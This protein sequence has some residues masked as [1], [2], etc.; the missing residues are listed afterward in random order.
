MDSVYLELYEEINFD[1]EIE[2]YTGCDLFFVMSHDYNNIGEE[3]Y[4]IINDGNYLYN[5]MRCSIKGSKWKPET[6]IF[7]MNYLHELR[8]LQIELRTPTVSSGNVAIY[9]T[10][11]I[12]NF[13]IA[14]RG[15]PRYISGN[16]IRDRIVR[17]SFVD[18]ILY[19]QL[20]KYLIYENCAS[21]QGKG[22]TKQRDILDKQLRSYY[23]T[24]NHSYKGYILLGDFS[25]FF[26][27][28]RHDI[29]LEDVKSK[30]KDDY[31]MMLL[32]TILKSFEIDVS[33]LT[34]EEY[35]SCLEEKFDSLAY[36]SIPDE[37]KTG[38][39]FMQKSV[40][41][42]DHTAQ[43]I[44]VYY[45]TPIDNYVKIVNSIKYYGRYMDDF[46]IISESKEKL[47]VLLDGIKEIANKL[48]L[49]LNEKK[50]RIVKLESGFTFLQTKYVPKESGYVIKKI[51]KKRI[52]CMKRKLRKLAKKMDDGEVSYDLIYDMYNS[53]ICNYKNLMTIKQRESL[54]SLYNSLFIY[55][56]I[57]KDIMKGVND[58]E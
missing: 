19:P 57:G 34:D 32:K 40:N 48:G 38:E 8:K 28:I 52:I 27:N 54:D 17:H 26:D 5:S 43:V 53:W 9:E 45:P 51:N 56:F 55:P 6:Q 49:F 16:I 47:L 31:A 58:Y 46:Y 1:I 18:N 12:K 11:R 42:G 44:G 4:H 23:N 3:L 41:I 36:L 15:K 20:T 13:L 29:F 35:S 25:K 33:C 21:I 30:I 37:Y 10:G 39:K 24:H 2:E 22:I 50:T 14:E 7:R